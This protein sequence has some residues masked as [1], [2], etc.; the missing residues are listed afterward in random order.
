MAT[1]DKIKKYLG[2]A[3]NGIVEVRVDIGDGPGAEVLLAAE[4]I[5]IDGK[6]IGVWFMHDPRPHAFK[7]KDE[8]RYLDDLTVEVSGGR[9]N[10]QTFN[11]RFTYGDDPQKNLDIFNDEMKNRKFFIEREIEET[12]SALDS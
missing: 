5:V 3:Y 1:G 2:E 7:I 4:D 12:R 6:I 11:M 9:D 8:T 10:N